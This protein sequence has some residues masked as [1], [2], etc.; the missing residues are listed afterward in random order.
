MTPTQQRILDQLIAHF[1]ELWLDAGAVVPGDNTHRLL[2]ELAV[3]LAG[4]ADAL[5]DIAQNAYLA[6]AVGQGL[7]R[8]GKDLQVFR[9]HGNGDEPDGLYRTRL[10]GVF[11]ALKTTRP[12]I[13]G[14]VQTLFGYYGLT[15]QPRMDE[16]AYGPASFRLYFYFPDVNLAAPATQGVEVGQLVRQ[17]RGAAIEASCTFVQLNP[18]AF[19]LNDIDSPLNDIDTPLGYKWSF[20]VDS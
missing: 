1:P 4:S 10:Q 8:W 12:A 13:L 20:T 7:D 16:F 11:G 3:A 17:T 18:I 14:A 5:A 9:K 19:T 6:S 2:S 15:Y